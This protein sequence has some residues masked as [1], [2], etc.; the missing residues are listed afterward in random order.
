MKFSADRFWKRLLAKLPAKRATPA[1]AFDPGPTIERALRDAGLT[2]ATMPPMPRRAWPSV[3]EA[4]REPVVVPTDDTARFIAGTHHSPAGF[5]HYKI[6]LPPNPSGAPRPLLVMLHGCTQDPDD[7]AA[8]TRMN[9]LAGKIGAVVLYP[10][11]GAHANGARCWNWFRP[12]DQ[13]RDH[14]EPAQLAA[15]TRHII[16]TENIDPRRVYAAG[17]SAGGAMAAI[18]GREYPDLFAAIG[19]HSG[20]APGAASDVPSAFAAMKQASGRSTNSEA[21]NPLPVIVFHGDSDATVHPANAEQVLQSFVA[22]GLR[23]SVEKSAACTHETYSRL[24]GPPT[25]ESWTI[26]GL[27]HAWSGGS[28]D[29]SYTTKQGPDASAEM[30]RFFLA[31]PKPH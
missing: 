20:L 31:H 29:G 26:H 19:V 9:L 18:L 25:A 24:F 5:R 16:A 7:F 13:Q 23:R 28:P 8:G 15:L 14:G 30:L 27:G 12:G 11:Q 10:T 22:A 21:A 4:E 2:P 17:L 1:T 3:D 6:F